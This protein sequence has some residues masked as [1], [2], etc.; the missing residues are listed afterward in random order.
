MD[1]NRN[2]YSENLTLCNTNSRIELLPHNSVT[3]RPHEFDVE[4]INFFR[5]LV[6][7]LD[8]AERS[9]CI[10]FSEGL[11]KFS[12]EGLLDIYIYIYIYIFFC[13]FSLQKLHE[14]MFVLLYVSPPVENS[15]F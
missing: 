12:G 2:S 10:F 13:I 6:S 4:T 8:S 15:A 3:V 1:W 7:E 5:L 14:Q 9:L 11:T